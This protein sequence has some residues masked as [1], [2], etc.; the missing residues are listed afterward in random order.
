MIQRLP[1]WSFSKMGDFRVA[2]S[3]GV[4]SAINDVVYVQDAQA[5]SERFDNFV[6]IKN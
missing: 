6:G 2:E 4:K 5:G 1:A 3:P